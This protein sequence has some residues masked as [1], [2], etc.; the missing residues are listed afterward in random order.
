VT[1]KWKARRG[2]ISDSL[3]P[4]LRA[5][6]TRSLF[7]WLDRKRMDAE[8]EVKL[9]QIALDSG[10][11]V[12]SRSTAAG[13]ERKLRG[14]PTVARGVAGAQPG[15]QPEQETIARDERARRSF[16]T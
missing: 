13:D 9:A 15:T 2:H 7:D 16:E 8:H 11:N 14:I 6:L 1:P 12:L 10:N 3:P 4:H 5:E